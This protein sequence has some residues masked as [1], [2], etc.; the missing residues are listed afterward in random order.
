MFVLKKW[1]CLL[2][3]GDSR[4]ERGMTTCRTLTWPLR[5]RDQPATMRNPSR[6]VL[7][8]RSLGRG[9]A[10][11][12][13]VRTWPASWRRLVAS[14]ARRT[15]SIPST[16]STRTTASG[17]CCLCR[18]FYYGASRMCSY[19]CVRE[20]ESNVSSYPDFSHVASQLYMKLGHCFF[21]MDWFSHFEQ[22]RR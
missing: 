7:P 22:H 10:R 5:F 4:C 18:V 12:A 1:Q 11:T 8:R 14:L 20:H 16:T 19:D 3:N 15:A 17:T 13:R 9:I 2:V 6:W 21:Y